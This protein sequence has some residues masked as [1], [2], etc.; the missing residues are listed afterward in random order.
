M[1]QTE[2]RT[3]TTSDKDV[4]H[5][6]ISDNRYG[7]TEHHYTRRCMG[8]KKYYRGQLAS[9]SRL[10]YRCNQANEKK[11]KKKINNLHHIVLE[12]KSKNILE[13]PSHHQIILCSIESWLIPRINIQKFNLYCNGFIIKKLN[14]WSGRT[15]IYTGWHPKSNP[16]L[17][18]R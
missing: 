2:R 13:I 7:Q 17:K 12:K 14:Y 15:H 4:Q 16:V 18:L 10:A 8:R 6:N 3:T 11:K 9:F 5:T 1:D